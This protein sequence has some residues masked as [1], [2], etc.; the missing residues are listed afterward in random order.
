MPKEYFWDKN[1]LSNENN[2]NLVLNKGIKDIDNPVLDTDDGMTRVQQGT[3][4]Y[5]ESGSVFGTPNRIHYWYMAISDVNYPTLIFQTRYAYS[6]NY[7]EKGSWIKPNVNKYE[8]PVGSGNKSNNI[9][10][11]YLSTIAVIPT[12]KAYPLRIMA[13]KSDT[14]YIFFRGRATSVTDFEIDYTT[15]VWAQTDTADLFYSQGKLRLNYQLFYTPETPRDWVNSV[16]YRIF[17]TDECDDFYPTVNWKYGQPTAAQRNLPVDDWPGYTK[18]LNLATNRTASD[19]SNVMPQGESYIGLHL[20]DGTDFNGDYVLLCM[21]LFHRCKFDGSLPASLGDG[22][23]D[24]GLA[25]MRDYV[26]DDVFQRIR[27]NDD[28]TLVT[29]APYSHY[30][31]PL[32]S[33]VFDRGLAWGVGGTLPLIETETEIIY[34]YSGFTSWHTPFSDEVPFPGT[35]IRC[36]M[37]KLTWRKD[38]FTCLQ[39]TNGLSADTETVLRTK[40]MGE[41]IKVNYNGNVKLEL[42][43]VNDNIIAGYSKNDC[44]LPVGDYL[45]QIATWGNKNASELTQFKMKWYLE[46]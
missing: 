35:D 3:M 14:D 36:K 28:D 32:E 7:G 27:G 37:G 12:D 30:K 4:Y 21:N 23:S 5:D 39:N 42:L 44:T 17:L 2:I 11:P 40:S 33:Q 43:D 13:T 20:K 24:F 46:G 8:H 6:D 31:S 18:T 29:I 16:G 26:N 45:G 38:G 9:V 25:L 22:Y 19:R 34:F 41:T 10:H 15:I 1:G